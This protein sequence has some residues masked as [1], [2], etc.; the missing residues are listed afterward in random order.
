[1]SPVALDFDACYAA[2]AGRDRRFDGQFVTAVRSTGI[3]C[4]PSCPALTPKA[5]N[6]TF[7]P[8]SA[9]AHLAGYRACKRCLPEAVPGSPAWN[10][11]EDVAARAMRLIGAGTVDREGVPGLA[12]RLGY[13]ERQ[14]G[15][16]LVDEL[17]AGALALARAQRAQTARHLLVSTTMPASDVAF[18]AGFSS[19]RQ[20]NDTIAEVFAMTPTALR[21]SGAPRGRAASRGPASE[22]AGAIALRLRAREPF[23]GG[24][25]VTWLAARAIG[26]LERVDAS[27]FSRAIALS[28]GI[29]A[30]ALEPAVD[31]VGVSARLTHLDDLPELLARL[32][33]LFD[34]D[35][36]PMTVDVALAMDPALAP[37]V[38]AA[39]GLR[40]PGTVDPFEMLVRAI[41]GQQ[42]TVASARTAVQGLVDELG[43]PL[44]EAA[45][46]TGVERAFPTPTVV[47]E[48]A[49]RVVRGP[50]GRRR[51]LAAAASAVAEGTLVLDA[52]RTLADLTRDLEAIPGIGP[53]TSHYVALRVLGRPDLLLTGDSAV[54]AGAAALGL[55]SAPRDLAVYAERHRP[56]R[57]YLM[58][59][60][61]RA[62]APARKEP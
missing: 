60:L 59:H 22:Q 40:V 43:A 10:L 4:R 17:G 56:W 57:S 30:V 35:A 48:N 61:W 42:V 54:R 31:H 53:W 27:A 52:G 15:R 13:S 26:G 12:R 58:M 24:E 49:E 38:S 29:A 2:V 37:S 50:A 7:Y 46:G 28:H 62:A 1:M 18:A 16:I 39:P 51:A 19:I 25:I 23:A 34:L 3:Y 8:T 36:D 6:C 47:A 45:R 5:A 41:L 55:P 9:A 21:A 14:L 32:R 44:P 33:R 20:F 11:R